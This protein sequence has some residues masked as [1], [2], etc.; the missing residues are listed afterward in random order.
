MSPS[1]RFIHSHFPAIRGNSPLPLPPPHATFIVTYGMEWNSFSSSSAPPSIM[2]VSIIHRHST[3]LPL[4]SSTE[5]Y[6][7]IVILPAPPEL[8]KNDSLINGHYSATCVSTPTP[9]PPLLLVQPIVS[10]VQSVHMDHQFMASTNSSAARFKN[11]NSIPR[12]VQR[13]ESSRNNKFIIQR[14]WPT[15][16]HAAQCPFNRPSI[17]SYYSPIDALNP[18][19]RH[20]QSGCMSC[21]RRRRNISIPIPL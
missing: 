9:N 19:L 15:W 4:R 12:S 7:D 10:A 2:L 6:C 21:D 16:L 14:H 13:F 8:H 18:H 3:T 1:Q 17:E 20:H 5:I 11:T